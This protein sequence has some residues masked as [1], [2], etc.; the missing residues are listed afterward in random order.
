MS[1]FAKEQLYLD[2]CAAYNV[3]AESLLSDEDYEKLKTDLTFEGS[4][5]ILMSREEIK[6]MVAANRY[7]KGKPI[8]SDEEFDTLRKKLKNKGSLAVKHEA[9]SC[10]LDES[11]RKVCKADIFPDEGKNAL[12]YT[13][14]LVLTALLFNEWAFWFKATCPSCGTP[15]NIYFGDILWV[16]GKPVESSVQTQCC[17][18]ACGVELV[19]DKKRMIVESFSK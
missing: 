6:F 5:V 19:A 2:C 7:N 1:L 13:P 18:K 17:N 16:S 8:M 4:Q 3:D 9:A 14:A 12:L 11:G 15:Q 10:K